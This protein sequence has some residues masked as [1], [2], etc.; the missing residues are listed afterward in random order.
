MQKLKNF[1]RDRSRAFELIESSGNVFQDLGFGKESA[2]LLLRADLMIAITDIFD[3]KGWSN[4]KAAKALGVKES[5]IS[6]LRHGQIT[7]FSVDLL[8]KFL[9]RLGKRVELKIK[10]IGKVA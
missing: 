7:K 9:A 6:E 2:N 8:L 10:N 1:D 3:S 5:R 4:A